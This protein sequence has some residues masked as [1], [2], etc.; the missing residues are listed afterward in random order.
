MTCTSDLAP[1]PAPSTTAPSPG[2]HLCCGPGAGGPPPWWARQASLP[3]APADDS[4]TTA[5]HHTTTILARWGLTHVLDDARTVVTELVANAHHATCTAGLTAPLG[6]RLLA[7]P[8]LLQVEV[9]DC[10]P[11]PPRLQPPGPPLLDGTDT[12]EPRGNG[13]LVVSEIAVC[14]GHT[15]RPDGGKIVHA[16]LRL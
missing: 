9:W 2:M 5:R 15:S 8:A 12:T 13:L 6:L 7:G 4:A 10:V 16:V 11:D 3:L 14:W 1:R